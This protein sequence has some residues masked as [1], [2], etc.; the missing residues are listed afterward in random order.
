MTKA[1]QEHLALVTVDGLIDYKSS[2]IPAYSC[3]DAN[4]KLIE[5]GV[6]G[7]GQ[8]IVRAYKHSFIFNN[9]AHAIDKYTELLT[10]P[11][12]D[13]FNKPGNTYPAGMPIY[14]VMVVVD[15]TLFKKGHLLYAMDSLNKA[16]SN[17]WRINDYHFIKKDICRI[18]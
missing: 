18:I 10:N 3:T 9:P 12:C 11:A 17:C 15:T 6:N 4:S 1:T 2:F 8:F 16:F 14:K 5:L 13:R 7:L